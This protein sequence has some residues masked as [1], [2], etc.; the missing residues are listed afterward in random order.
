[1]SF[2][3]PQDVYERAWK[4]MEAAAVKAGGQDGLPTIEK[5]ERA[6][7][8]AFEETLKMERASEAERQKP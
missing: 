7:A 1:M 5:M 4:M 2:I 8:Q 6:L 3:D